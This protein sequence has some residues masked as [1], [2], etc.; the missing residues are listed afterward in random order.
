[1]Q[2]LTRLLLIAATL[3]LA[4]PSYA[5]D[6]ALIAKG[7]AK[8]TT[9]VACHGPD[10]NSPSPAWPNIA[11][12]HAKYTYQQLKAYKLG[13]AK[14]GRVNALMAGIVAS[15]S[16]DDMQALAAY[17][18]SLPHRHQATPKEYVAPGQAIYR[19]GD[20]SNGIAACIACHGPKGLGNPGAAFPLLSGQHAEYTMQQLNAY[21]KGERKTDMAAIM[22]TTAKR[23]TDEQIKA[24]AYY[25]QGLH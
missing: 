16:D 3:V 4:N 5:V 2:T 1:M 10:G 15:L 6:K 12:Q 8:S 23:M 11:G 17:Y 24:V 22:R 13:N 25:I 20:I 18:A 7:K 19:G 21:K 14:G 9:C